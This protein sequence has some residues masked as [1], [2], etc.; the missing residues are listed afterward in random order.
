VVDC[1]SGTHPGGYAGG[2]LRAR[3]PVRLRADAAGVDVLR[4]RAGRARLG[5]AP[6]PA[7]AAGGQLLDLLSVRAPPRAGVRRHLL[8]RHTPVRAAAL[9]PV[10]L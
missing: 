7:R 9:R 4:G 3:L 6:T 8:Q 2:Q 5:P 10:R 1:R